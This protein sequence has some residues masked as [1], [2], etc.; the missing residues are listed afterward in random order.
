MDRQFRGAELPS[1][2]RLP[3]KRGFK[4]MTALCDSARIRWVLRLHELKFMSYIGQD[5][6]NQTE[7]IGFFGSSCKIIDD[8]HLGMSV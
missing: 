4:R 2:R 8:D 3:A 1:I 7:K 5:H 6:L